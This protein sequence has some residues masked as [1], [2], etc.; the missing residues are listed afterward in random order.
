MFDL[1]TIKN[2]H[3][4]LSVRIKYSHIIRNPYNILRK[5][6]ELIVKILIFNLK[7]NCGTHAN[8]ENNYLNNLFYPKVFTSIKLFYVIKK[9]HI[10]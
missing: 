2:K 6:Q 5:K 7:G 10:Y 3:G 1:T 8:N 9:E 4:I